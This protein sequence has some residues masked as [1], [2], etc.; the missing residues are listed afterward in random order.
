MTIGS[1][2]WIVRTGRARGIR[3]RL[4]GV[5]LIACVGFAADTAAQEDEPIPTVP[6]GTPA[7]LFPIQAALPTR[8]GAWPG[9][10]SSEQ[11]VLETLQAE[12]SFAFGEERDAE[13]W[14][15]PAEIERRLKQNPTLRVNPHR[16]AYQGLLRKPKK[17]DQIPEPLHSQMRQ[18]AALF[19]ARLVVLPMRVWY[20]PEPLD[21]QG[22][23]RDR[24]GEPGDETSAPE[25]LGRAVLLAAVIDTRRSA[26]LWHG[27]IEGAADTL[28]SSLLLTS[29]AFRLADHL[30]P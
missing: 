19:N 13:S 20:K 27:E 28:D 21:E 1:E 30:I 6:P 18:V 9:G 25:P 29:L 4:V 7:V 12:I 26:V 11:E 24:E 15:L 17:H 14:A 10:V 5:A 2:T 3:A 22:P 16:L 8:G 23:A